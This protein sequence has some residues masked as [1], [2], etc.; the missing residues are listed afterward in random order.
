MDF[1]FERKKSRINLIRRKLVGIWI[2]TRFFFWEFD[3]ETDP[4]FSRRF[5]P[6]PFFPMVGSGS[7]PPGSATLIYI[8]IYVRPITWIIDIPNIYVRRTL[9][10]SIKLYLS[11]QREREREIVGERGHWT[12]G[13]GRGRIGKSE[14]EKDRERKRELC[15]F[16]FLFLLA[17]KCKIKANL[18]WLPLLYRLQGWKECQVLGGLLSNG[19]NSSPLIKKNILGFIKR[20]ILLV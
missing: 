12:W 8:Y 3:P 1:Y 11:W 16:L 6:N 4:V 9:L 7:I 2:R 14:K 5:D 20:K 19:S 15:K 10:K 13:G 18:I 17:R